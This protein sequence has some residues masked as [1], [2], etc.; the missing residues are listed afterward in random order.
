[1]RRLA[2]GLICA[3]TFCGCY[4][5]EEWRDLSG[6]NRGEHKAWEDYRLCQE[7]LPVSDKSSPLS[8]RQRGLTQ[9]MMD[10]MAKRG[11]MSSLQHD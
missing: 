9:P 3:A 2:L 7:S 11:W 1:M 6:Q 5:V 10:C 8:D 4:R